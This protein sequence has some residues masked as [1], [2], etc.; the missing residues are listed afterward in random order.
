MMTEP[1]TGNLHSYGFVRFS[2]ESDQQHALVEIQGA[3]CGN[4]PTRLSTI[5]PKNKKTKNNSGLGAT[6][7]SEWAEFMF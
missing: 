1:V 2:D 6:K 4:R 7:M 5:M 3:H